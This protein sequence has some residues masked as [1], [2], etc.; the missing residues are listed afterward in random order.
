M[1]LDSGRWHLPAVD[2]GTL[3]HCY[4]C[5]AQNFSLPC[6]AWY[7]APTDEDGGYPCTVTE[8]VD[9]T[10]GPGDKFRGLFC[11][12]RKG[13]QASTLPLVE[14]ELSPD[15]PNYKAVEHYRNCFWHWR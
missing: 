2:A 4:H 5:L 7:P 12:V 1:A 3:Q 6:V 11:V 8:L 14:L 10:T 9:P 13:K 15:N